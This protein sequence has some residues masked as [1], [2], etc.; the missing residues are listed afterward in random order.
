MRGRVGALAHRVMLSWGFARFVIAFLAGAVGALAMP[1]FGLLPAFAVSMTIAVWLLDGAAAD[2]GPLLARRPCFRAAFTGWSFGFGYFVAGLWWLGAAF[3]VEPD[4]FALPDAAGRRRPARRAGPVPRPGLR[5]WR[6]CSG[7]PARC[8]S[9]RWR[10]GSASSEWL[11]GTVLTGFPW[12]APG[13][14]LADHLLLAQAA[15]LVG[16]HG[17]TPIAIAI[18]ASPAVIAT[19]PTPRARWTA[20]ALALAAL[21]VLLAFGWFRMPSGTVRPRWRA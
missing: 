7:R 5:R 8:G 6:G 20:P 3:L 18:A 1:P 16:L 21:A 9:W 12:N 2:V 4:Q 11:R 10:A 14:A 15:S 17:L 19:G 13:M